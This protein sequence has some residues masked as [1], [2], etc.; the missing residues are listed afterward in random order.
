MDLSKFSNALIEKQE[1]ILNQLTELPYEELIKLMASISAIISN[2]E[3]LQ[4]TEDIK[5]NK[6]IAEQFL[7]DPRASFAKAEALMKSSE[8]YAKYKNIANLKQCALREL[9]IVRIQVQ[10]HLKSRVS[11]EQIPYED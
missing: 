11:D 8:A 10:Y 1:I 3:K 4:T 9:Q 6:I 5:C 7:N 2:L